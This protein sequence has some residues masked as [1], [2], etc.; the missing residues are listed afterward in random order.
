MVSLPHGYGLIE[1]GRSAS[2]R[3]GP[4]INFLTDSNH[5]D[6]LSRVPYH[7]HVPVRITPVLEDGIPVG[8]IDGVE[9]VAANR[10]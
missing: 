2:G 8:M 1:E 7:K 6:P 9:S 10:R 3:G 5:C 4:A